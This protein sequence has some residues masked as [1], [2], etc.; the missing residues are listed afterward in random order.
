MVGHAGQLLMMRLEPDVDRKQCNDAASP[1][2][3]GSIIIWQ[4][5]IA[6]PWHAV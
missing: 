6:Q 2:A 4:Q 5:S 3:T 1:P